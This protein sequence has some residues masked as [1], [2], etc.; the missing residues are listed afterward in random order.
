MATN[1]ERLDLVYEVAFHAP[2]FDLPMR[3]AALLKALY[4]AI[5]PRYS[6]L[7][8]NMQIFGGNAMS[9]V[10]VRMTLFNGSGLIDVTAN[11]LTLTF[12]DVRG[13]DGI[14]ICKECIS[15]SELVL[16]EFFP[17]LRVNIVTIRPT[18]VMTLENTDHK[19]S[20]YLSQ[21]LQDALSISLVESIGTSQ[22]PGA[23]LTLKNKREGWSVVFHVFQNQTADSSVIVSCHAQYNDNGLILGLDERHNHMV[24]LLDRFLER[25][26]LA[27]SDSSQNQQL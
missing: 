19:G 4:E 7:M 16:K 18:I 27:I 21:V 24:E 25:L 17:D 10:R 9:D 22:Y 5:N 15:L 1:V 26:G 12:N 8:N 2:A 11:N 13:Q 20:G 3:G 14:A 23:N 6:I